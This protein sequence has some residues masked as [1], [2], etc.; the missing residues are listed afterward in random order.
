MG[1][2]SQIELLQ[3]QHHQKKEKLQTDQLANLLKKYGGQKHMQVPGE[4]KV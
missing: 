3:N 1:M 2:P 4:V